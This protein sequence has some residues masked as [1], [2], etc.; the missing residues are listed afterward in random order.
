MAER[1]DSDE[2]TDW[3]YETRPLDPEETRRVR[4]L[5]KEWDRYAWLWRL[6]GRV[7]AWTGGVILFVWTSRDVLGRVFKAIFKTP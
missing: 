7:S 2:A 1:D 6:I 3:H 5:I 4:R